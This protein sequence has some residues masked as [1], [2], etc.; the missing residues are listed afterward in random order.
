MQF[1]TARQVI[2]DAYKTIGASTLARSIERARLGRDIQETHYPGQ[3]GKIVH[4]LEAGMVISRVEALPD[5]P[6]SLV[7]Y[8]FGPFTTEEL[9]PEGE[10]IGAALFGSVI[11]S[12]LRLPGQEAGKTPSVGVRQQLASLCLA[13]LYHHSQTTWPYRRQGLPTP[14]AVRDWISQRGTAL[15]G[16]WSYGNRPAWRWIWERCLAQ[17][18][19]WEREGLAPV[20]ELVGEQAVARRREADQAFSTSMT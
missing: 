3:D 14:Q 17:L 19:E 12:G 5:V 2:F 20:A 4:G 11:D 16:R 10:I 18:D 15:E 1:R 7:L 8:C 9:E 13:A 6:C